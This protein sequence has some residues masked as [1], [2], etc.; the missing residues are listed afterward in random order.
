MSS[1]AHHHIRARA[2]PHQG[3]WQRSSLGQVTDLV[4][5]SDGASLAP[6][7]CSSD[8]DLVSTSLGRSRLWATVGHGVINEVYWPS[9]GEPELRDLTLYLVGPT[10][11]IDLKRVMNYEVRLGRPVMPAATIAHH[12]AD[13]TLTIEPLPDP[14]RD[15]LLIRFSVEGPYSLVVIAAPHLGG[16]G[17]QN[18]AAVHDG[19]LHTVCGDVAMCLTADVP[20]RQCSVGVV[21]TSDGWQD[22]ARHGSLTWA[23]EVA[24][25]GNVALTAMAGDSS[26]VLALAFSNSPVGARTLARSALAEGFDAACADFV[27]RWQA[28]AARL[29][30]E[31]VDPE[32][33]ESVLTSA[34]VIKTHEDRTYPGAIAASLSVPWGNT[35][36]SPGGYH[37]V[38]PRDAALSALGMLAVGQYDDAVHVLSRFVATQQADGHWVQNEYPSGVVYWHGLQ[39]DEAAFPVVL[40]AKVAEMCPGLVHG[41]PAMIRRAVGFVASHGPATQQDRWEEN[42]GINPFTVAVAVAAL[43]SGAAWLEAAERDEALL[44]ADEWNARLDGWCYATGTPLAARCGVEGYYVRV[45]QPDDGGLQGFVEVRNQGDLRVAANEHVSME[46]SYLVRLGLRSGDDPRIRNTVRVVDAVLRVATPSGDVFH[47]YD[48]D[49]YGE[50]ADGSAFDGSGIGRG[51]PLLAG[52]RGHLAWAMGDDVAPYLRTMQ[53]CMSSGG[54]IPE[55]VWD[56]DPIPERGLVPGRPTGSAMPLVWAHA[57]FVKLAT[58]AARGAPIDA[59]RAVTERYLSARAAARWSWRDS[60]PIDDIPP[61]TD[62]LIEADQPFVVHLGHDGWTDAHDVTADPLPFGRYGVNVGRAQLAG[63]RTVEFTRRFA[64]GWEG[65]DH[66]IGGPP[67]PR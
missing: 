26:G 48:H 61:A 33:R 12:G 20:L 18:I 7:W 66:S 59:P 10:G 23:Y 44:L 25:P 51:W 6:T 28:W 67:P 29:R 36:D 45:V 2:A 55:Q 35:S 34:G 56:S 11:W 14:R 3:P 57:E 30:L 42:P 60:T 54:L 39:L 46:F 52:E 19:A 43:V 47:R 53:R 9:T 22:L 4:A 64:S 16:T 37:L 17:T 13:Y 38:W 50:H 5:P 8:K 49:G 41:V 1:P 58:L 21:G 31:G 15:V 62:L 32:F 27:A 24:G 63:W 65:V 40:A